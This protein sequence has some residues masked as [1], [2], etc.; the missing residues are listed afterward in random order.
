[1]V[2][3]ALVGLP[4]ADVTYHDS[5]WY[6]SWAAVWH[7][8][9]AW[10]TPLRGRQLARLGPAG[11]FAYQ[12]SVATSWDRIARAHTLVRARGLDLLPPGAPL[13][14]IRSALIQ[15]RV[16]PATVPLGHGDGGGGPDDDF[17]DTPLLLDDL[18]ILTPVTLLATHTPNGQ[19]RQ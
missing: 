13:P 5:A 6:G 17:P 10:V 2:C 18:M 19:L 15:G 14:A 7:Y 11:G 8:V 9:R 16:S 4:T 12:Q 3:R 1:M